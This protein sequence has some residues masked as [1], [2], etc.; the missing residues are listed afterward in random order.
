MNTSRRRRMQKLGTTAR[1]VLISVVMGRVFRNPTPN[2]TKTYYLLKPSNC[3]IF[4]VFIQKTFLPKYNNYGVNWGLRYCG[5]GDTT[6]V[7]YWY[8]RIQYVFGLVLVSKFICWFNSIRLHNSKFNWNQIQV[9]VHT[10][11]HKTK[12]CTALSSPKSISI[13]SSTSDQRK[14]IL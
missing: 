13:L 6:S 1:N 5:Y 10:F 12:P 9:T 14:L 3:P 7:L 8:C 2:Y 11:T 4:Y